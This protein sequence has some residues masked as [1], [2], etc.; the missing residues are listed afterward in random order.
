LLLFTTDLWTP[1]NVALMILTPRPQSKNS[2]RA[3]VQHFFTYTLFVHRLNA[4][5]V[6]NK[7]SYRP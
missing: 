2:S 4:F 6:T 3:P 5:K 1:R 7:Q